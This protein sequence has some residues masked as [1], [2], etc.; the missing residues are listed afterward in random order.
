MS[1][2][3]A[4]AFATL[5]ILGLAFL[6]TWPGRLALRTFLE[7]WGSGAT[8][9]TLRLG[10]V[11]LAL[12]KGHASATALTLSLPGTAI[13]AQ[14]VALDW[15][16]SGPR[17][18][19]L[20]PSIVVTESGEPKP[21]PRP[22]I[23]LAAQPWRALERLAAAQV[24]D[25]RLELRDAKGTP[26]LVLGRLDAELAE[27]SLTLRVEEGAL[28]VG[29]GARL[30]PVSGEAGLRLDDGVLVVER[31]RLTS[32]TTALEL[33]A[34]L[35]RILPTTATAT[36]RAAFD[37]TLVGALAPGTE[38]Q[39]RVEAAAAIEVVDD[40]LTGTL[41]ASS[42]ALTVAG[43]GPWVVAGRGRLESD[44]LRLDP[45]TAEGFGGRV[46][47]TGPLAL[48]ASA[49][50]DVTVRA[51]GL[52]P[53]LLVQRLQGKP[54]PLSARASG[55][56]R[57][58]TRGWDVAAAR[59]DGRLELVPG[60]GAGLKPAASAT[61]RL[62]GR[63]LALADA[64]VSTHGASVEGDAELSA[65]GAVKA[66]FSAELPLTALPALA[67]D[68]GETLEL[69][70]IAG[71]L[72]AEGEV[73]GSRAAPQVTA[74][75]SG[76]GLALSGKPVGLEAETRYE[77]GRLSVAPLVLR[78]GRGQA[79]L[80][81]TVPLSPTDAWDLA[82]EVDSL[83]IAPAL[84]FAGLD[85]SGP[86]TGRLS[87]TGPR[88]EP[89]GRASLRA[90]TH[91]PRPDEGA[92][93]VEDDVHIELEAESAGRRVELT[94]LEAQLAGGRLG[95]TARFDAATGAVAANLDAAGLAVERL[96]ILP[97]SAR[98]ITGTLAGRLALS[99]TSSAPAG[100]LALGVAEPRFDGAALPPLSLAARSDGRALSVT[101]SSDTTAFVSGSGR[102]EGNWPLRLVVDA[103]AL[104]LAALVAAFP[105]LQPAGTEIAASG[106]LTLDLP[107]RAPAE[108]RYSSSDLAFSGR[109]Q[110]LEWRVA[111]FALAGGR[112]ALEVSG[113]KL[114]AGG[115]WFSAQGR[116]GL[117]ATSPFDL[118]LAGNLDFA[119]LD[120]ALPG[121]TFGGS[122]TLKLHVGG[123]VEAPQLEGAL[124]LA[125]LRGRF[126]GAWVNDLDM[127]AR[128]EGR[129]LRV[130]SLQ[131]NVLGGKLSASGGIAIVGKGGTTP[132]FQFALTDVDL[133]RFLD[134]EV[135]QAADSPSLLVS[136]D[137]EL[138][139]DAPSVERVSARGTLTRFEMQSVE[140]GAL[141]L[142][143]PVAWSVVGGALAIE[144]VRLQGPLGALEARVSGH[145]GGARPAGEAALS[146]TVDL[147][148]FSSLLPDTSTSGPAAIDVRASYAGEAWRLDGH[149]KL[150]KAR[151]SLDTLNFAVSDVAG[152]LRLEGDRASLELT[153]N[154]GDGQ[155]RTRGGMRFGEASL[156]GVADFE[157]TAERVPL[158]Y[159]AGF[160]GRA[161]GTLRLTGEPGHYRLAGD[162]D[163]RQGFYTADF[164]AQSQSLERLDWQL[165]ALEGG[166]LAD[167]IALDV[168]VRLAE[169]LRIRNSTMRLD[170]EGT[171]V[172]SGTLAQP[173]SEG[174]VSLREGGELTLGRARVRVSGG[175]VVLN[176]YPAGTPDVDFQGA[177][178]VGGIAMTLR[179]RGALDDLQL[180]LDSD[181]SGLSQTDL[182]TLLLTG[183]TAAAAASEGGVVVAEQL[184]MALGGV[185]QK[186]V[187]ETLLIDVAPDRS[188]LS[189]DIDPTQRLH[190]GTRITQNLTVLYSAALDGTEQRWTVEL[191]PGGGR[192]RFRA[193][194]EDDNTFS[195]EGTDRFSFELWNRGRVGKAPREVER[196]ASLGF[197]GTL[198]LAEDQLRGATKLK[199]GRR[200][201]GLQREQAAD[202][203]QA[204]LA[205][206]GYRS[207]S[208]EAISK[209]APKGVELVLRVE[210]GLL[211]QFKWSGDDPGKKTRQEAEKAFTAFSTPEAAAAQVARVALH[212]LQADGYYG[213]S[214]EPRAT[215]VEDRV[216]VALHVARG[217]KG[218]SVVVEFEGNEAL[219]DEALLAVLPKPGSLEFFEALDPR[220]ARISG[221][222]R[223]AYAATGHLRARVSTRRTSFDAGTGRL[224]VRI[225]VRERSAST[226]AAIELPEEILDPDVPGP[227]LKL[228]QGEPFDLSAY[229]A[230]RDALV[231][232]YRSQGWIEAQAGA[233]IQA[234][235]GSVTVRYHVDKGARPRIGSVRV[236]DTGRTSSSLI[237]R[238]LKLR[239]GDY[240]KP[241]SLADSRERL[242]DLG[243]YRS[244]DVRTEPR[245]GD[246]VRDVVV[247]LVHKPD[248]SL[249]YGLRYTTQGSS[250]TPEGAPT[251][252]S[253]DRIQG[254]VAV[255]LNNP[256]GY[257]VKTRG[258]TFLTKS[259]QTW[260][261]SFDAATLVGWR[262][263][264]QL[265][266]FDD[267][268][269]DDF[270]LAGIESRVRGTT[271]QQSRA[272]WRDRRSRRWHDRL[273]LQWGYTYK[274]IEYFGTEPGEVL[275]AG[276]R[277]FVTL[278]AIGDERDSLTDP[279]RGVFWTLTSEFARTKLG[280]DV[281]YVRLYG[282]LFAYVP[283]GPVVWAQGL[284]VG[285]V[286]GEDP[287]FLIENRFRAG[288]STTV[289]GF[290]QNALGPQTPDGGSLG[291]QAVVV[292]NQELRFPIF[293][294]LKG[295]VF[296]DAGNVWAF[297]RELEFKDLRQSMGVGLRYM[298]PFG[299]I[300]V[301]YAWVLDR[302]EGESKGRFVFG[303]GHA[304]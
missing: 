187:G 110:T 275:L 158:N 193:I 87:V 250:S 232:W 273:R 200:Y 113:F 47:A 172:A 175:R 226:V 102:L 90:E 135:R 298:F 58:T 164:S 126:E 254:A 143:A 220:S 201:S 86:A 88:D 67:A 75:L 40:R 263:R 264:T 45:L 120:P 186:G 8:G 268:A 235:S 151:L 19:L 146:G 27:R 218:T 44:R 52:D 300:R 24:E 284:R 212:R 255:E 92:P 76:D 191:N 35:Q 26:W 238:S 251:A 6:H 48:A 230:D 109:Q 271:L 258:Y 299:P 57:V 138:H 13:E 61:L 34:R 69:H 29:D 141:S 227:V 38:A 176:G 170:M 205:R 149:V 148:A 197:D 131:A 63:T 192:F 2:A 56:L 156:L 85:G 237:R 295:G 161:G 55:A 70:E 12:W 217:A 33:T 233:S 31:A 65:A 178:S 283:I 32:G 287:L 277:G 163:V 210:A 71:R 39:G 198:P 132:R 89:K 5:V 213:A 115:A 74:R 25:G 81:G 60:T 182:V 294:E 301:E 80:T 82:G 247:G 281:D 28:G 73:A 22:A 203:V 134:R 37:E 77:P 95:G 117:A 304:F 209:P 10:Q 66:R 204:R 290:P 83:D 127:D 162:V 303:L 79:T 289:R 42:K 16:R 36:A 266:V 3:V 111:P 244:V 107:L 153:G 184:A 168:N 195:V 78:S 43:V 157:L 302:Q 267:D 225:P 114:E 179:A 166:S 183:R 224:T 239:E 228:R 21:A 46:E 41:D 11:E 144:P 223:L 214:V 274:N 246:E 248:V 84:A 17:L 215:S 100:E 272:L 18:T 196:L 7:G 99:G 185:L 4:L 297:S 140:G 116:A 231:A 286:P 165:A 160:R 130:E 129:E 241:T 98:R 1:V 150:E 152:E 64:R 145:A 167:Q 243:V 208:V 285:S 288:G 50:T 174:V 125:D 253:D 59:G 169:P 122:G 296:W 103:K 49:D 207:A 147:R 173:T 53:A 128:F 265:F 97:A 104:P 206:E 249:E 91:L 219:S 9:G 62:R 292:V 93:R 30:T 23:G 190:L 188:L 139:G 262:V 211:V 276:N 171:L 222:V 121:R 291:G 142:L 269:D 96:P 229:V 216:D 108:L 118:E 101:G 123:T 159:P 112:D 106:S 256:F 221:S 51:H 14:R 279:T 133:A 260:G 137:G 189:D 155:L 270:L 68:L 154:S 293:R 54:L 199:P 177:T 105:A 240:L 20:R 180:T 119:A 236:V 242:S 15:S 194:T 72:L 124:Q 136:L 257:G 278:A 234:R 245:P 282:Q 94:R 280:S 202:R 261:V 181:R 252:P 259:R